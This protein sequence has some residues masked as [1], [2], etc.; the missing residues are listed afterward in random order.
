[1]TSHS[2]RPPTYTLLFKCSYRF[3]TKDRACTYFSFTLLLVVE[4]SIY[5]HKPL[6]FLAYHSLPILSTYVQVGGGGEVDTLAQL[7][8]DLS[9]GSS[10]SLSYSG[11][12]PSWSDCV[13]EK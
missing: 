8:P 6:V 1:M 4:V 3:L 10:C 11:S 2:W 5:H 13:V 9:S 12:N 7:A